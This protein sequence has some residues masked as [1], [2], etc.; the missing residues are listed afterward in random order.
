VNLLPL[1]PDTEGIL[2]RKLFCKLPQDACVVNVGRGAHLVEED[3]L[4][5]IRSGHLAGARLDVFRQEPLPADHP[6]WGEARISI[7]SHISAET[8]KEDSLAQIVEKIRMLEEGRPI[9]G[10]IERSRGY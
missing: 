10:M 6:F 8:V 7:T 1:T 4:D 2:D 5:A 9:L 3:L